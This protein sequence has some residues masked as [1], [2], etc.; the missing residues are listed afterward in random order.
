MLGRRYR[1]GRDEFRGR[2]RVFVHFCFDHDALDAAEEAALLDENTMRDLEPRHAECFGGG[3]Q[4]FFETMSFE[5]LG[6]RHGLGTPVRR[7]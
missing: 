7:S 1:R 3:G 4:C 5:P 6:R 2:L